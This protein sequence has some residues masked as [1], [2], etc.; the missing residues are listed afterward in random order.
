MTV[1]EF[2]KSKYADNKLEFCPGCGA[3]LKNIPDPPRRDADVPPP[4]KQSPA[5]Q[6]G[7]GR[8]PSARLIIG[9]ISVCVVVIV[10]LFLL[11][12]DRN[13]EFRSQNSASY[14]DAEDISAHSELFE[15][16]F[17]RML[18]SRIWG[19]RTVTADMAAELTYLSLQMS[20]EEFYVE[21]GFDD[22]FA[23]D[24]TP[25]FFSEAY[26]R[27]DN[28][29]IIIRPF[30]GLQKLDTNISVLPSAIMNMAGLKYLSC[31]YY[32][33]DFSQIESLTSLETLL[34]SGYSLKTL[35]GIETFPALKELSLDNA[36][37]TDLSPLSE[38]KSLVSLSLNRCKDVLNLD[39]IGDF[40]DL[41]SLS[42]TDSDSL[43][44]SF[45]GRL[46]LLKSLTVSGSDTKTLAFAGELP[47]LEYLRLVENSEVKFL[48]SFERMAG[49][50]KELVLSALYLDDVDFLYDLVN[51]EKL[52][53]YS[54]PSVAP[55]SVMTR[56]EELTISPGWSV[57]TLAPL[58]NLT[59]LKKL[60]FVPNMGFR[61]WSN[62]VF[63]FLS[64]LGQLEELSFAGC[65]LYFN[66]DPVYTLKNL[67]SL[68]YSGNTVCGNFSNIKNL[69]GI[70]RLNLNKTRFASSFWV[71]SDG[72]V[73]NI[74]VD[75]EQT[76]DALASNVA[77][78][79]ALRELDVSNT[80]LYDISF[81][82]NLK[83]IEYFYASNNYITD[84][85]VLSELPALKVADLSA[86]AVTNWDALNSLNDSVQIIGRR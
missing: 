30:K 41:T 5:K 81:L 71:Q 24:F 17:M 11:T 54:P 20:D 26:D 10:W 7:V 51:L 43:D 53:L 70:E 48:P 3:K 86:N 77:A 2:C 23:D 74:G 68:D 84:V 21:Y 57:D 45:I 12:E 72:F 69:A 46:K 38:C 82:T 42:I 39:I 67:K 32:A 6:S 64:N 60:V 73:T 59:L 83:N 55:L 49:S 36:G 37:V 28:I 79:S 15:G 56:L 14:I 8:Q 25:G 22:P 65:D 40:A 75:G 1:C 80:D 4:V 35:T 27:S 63:S 76:M 61:P 16:E 31:S 62:N 34:I 52:T 9:I 44:L 19:A 85:F 13:A 66:A 58:G 50:L 29:D 47:N 78:L 18:A 33:E